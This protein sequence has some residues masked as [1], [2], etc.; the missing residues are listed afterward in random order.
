MVLNQR[1]VLQCVASFADRHRPQ[2]QEAKARREAVV[3]FLGGISRIAQQNHAM[4]Q[5]PAVSI[6]HPDLG[7]RTLDERCHH[8]CR[9]R[10]CDHMADRS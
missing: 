7:T 1:A 10:V 2:Q 3:T 9:A 5:L 4:A 8:R 6:S